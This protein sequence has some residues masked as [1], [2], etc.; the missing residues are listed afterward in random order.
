MIDGTR[1]TFLTPYDD[2]QAPLL[3]LLNSATKKIRIADYSFNLEPV[4]QI[5]IDKF[6]SG[7]DVSV[8]LDKSQAAGKSEVPEVQQLKDAGVPLAIGS[9]SKGKI[10]HLKVAIVDDQWV[11]SGSYNFTGTAD[12]EDNFFDVESNPTRAQAFTDYWQRVHDYIKGV[13]K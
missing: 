2:A 8:V 4:V 9:S 7:I 11:G 12:L 1:K 10:M 3:A 13:S 5:L 6:K